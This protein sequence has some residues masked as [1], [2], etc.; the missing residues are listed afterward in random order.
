MAGQVINIKVYSPLKL[1]SGLTG[2]CF[3]MPY[4]SY[5]HP[6]GIILNMFIGGYSGYKYRPTASF[7][8]RIP[9][10]NPKGCLMNFLI[11]V[12]IVVVIVGLSY[13]FGWS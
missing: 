11:V 7:R 2:N 1:R 12:I 3:E 13:L 6:L 4:F 8:N 9:K 5:C 10:V